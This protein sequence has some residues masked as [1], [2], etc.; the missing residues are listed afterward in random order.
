MIRLTKV[1]NAWGVSDFKETL[2]HE[3]ESMDA[4]LLPLQQGLSQSSYTSGENFCVIVL[5]VSEESDFIRAKTGIFYTGIIAGC[6]CAD[7]PTPVNEITEY[8]EV[9]FD[10]NKKTADTVVTLLPG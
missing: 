4:D 7:D 10:I 8:C 9:Q 1:L 3:V 5:D 2:K 6:S